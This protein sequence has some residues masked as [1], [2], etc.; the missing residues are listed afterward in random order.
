MPDQ[1]PWIVFKGLP[2]TLMLGAHVRIDGVFDLTGRPY[3]DGAALL[4]FKDLPLADEDVVKVHYTLRGRVTKVRIAVAHDPDSELH[5]RFYGEYRELAPGEV[6]VLYDGPQLPGSHELK[7]D[8]RDG[9]KDRRILLA[10][11]YTLRVVL[12]TELGSREVQTVIHIAAPR[13]WNYALDTAK[14]VVRRNRQN[15]STERGVIKESSLVEASHAYQAQRALSDGTHFRGE[16]TSTAA[17]REA[18]GFMR[19]AAVSYFGAHSHPMGL[20]F[21]NAVDGSQTSWLGLVM[22][23]GEH[24]PITIDTVSLKE[25]PPDAFRDVFLVVLGGCRAGNVAFAPQQI[26]LTTSRRVDPGTTSGHKDAS[27]NKAIQRYR[28]LVG[29]PTGTD[30]D[31][32]LLASLG[33]T[34]TPPYDAKT[35]VRTVQVALSVL[36]TL[37]V[38]DTDPKEAAKGRNVA[39]GI[40]GGASQLAMITYQGKVGLNPTGFPDAATL[41]RMGLGPET[42]I[43]ENVAQTLVDKGA[44]IVVAFEDFTNF[45]PMERWSE[46][47]WQLLSGGATIKEAIAQ[48]S[49]AAQ[50]VPHDFTHVAR[51][52]A[53]DVTAAEQ[54]TLLPARYGRGALP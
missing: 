44:E 46:T 53:R 47:F 10:G 36:S 18:L 30:I 25:L 7:W 43:K 12:D 28:Q 20:V 51:V 4:D 11:T 50:A 41:T 14:P 40:W 48:A 3:H 37:L 26:L 16:L 21:E 52:F 54:A 9:T 33:V 49:R 29:L 19:R 8:G 22:M 31:E 2:N 5:R 38:P 32:S 23:G 13:A 45:D 6:V 42:P 17:A 39:S 1:S 34:A 15:G 35:A 24:S 27:T